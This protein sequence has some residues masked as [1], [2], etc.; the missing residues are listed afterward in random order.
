MEE[1][2]YLCPSGLSSDSTRFV[3]RMECHFLVWPNSGPLIGY[4]EPFW[5]DSCTHKLSQVNP[6]VTFPF[7][8]NIFITKGQC[9]RIKTNSCR[10]S[11]PG[12]CYDISSVKGLGKNVIPCELYRQIDGLLHIFSVGSKLYVL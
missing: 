10:T 11:D 12:K 5:P 8:L 6:I 3:T 9:L 2:D 1:G 4:L 7:E